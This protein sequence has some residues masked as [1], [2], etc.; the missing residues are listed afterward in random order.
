MCNTVASLDSQD[1]VDVDVLFVQMILR[2]KRWISLWV[3][4]QI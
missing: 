3:K 1:I 2:S 4:M